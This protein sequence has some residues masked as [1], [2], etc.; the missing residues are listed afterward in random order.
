[1]NLENFKELNISELREIEGGGRIG[2]IVKGAKKLWRAAK[3]HVDD[4]IDGWNEG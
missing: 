1:M 3:S 2:A 4:F